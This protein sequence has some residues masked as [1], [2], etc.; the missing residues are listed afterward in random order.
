M[1]EGITGESPAAT[2]LDD[3]FQ[4]NAA[5]LLKDVVFDHHYRLLPFERFVERLRSERAR[6]DGGYFVRPPTGPFATLI[7]LADNTDYDAIARTIGIWRLQSCP[8]VDCAVVAA[9]PDFSSGALVA[10]L[11]KW[12]AEPPAAILSTDRTSWGA[13]ANSAY[14]IFARPG[15]AINPSLCVTME[16][17]ALGGPFDLFYWNELQRSS[18]RSTQ[19]LFKA[20]VDVWRRPRFERY[21]LQHVAYIGCGFA[22]RTPLVLDFDGDIVRDLIENEGHLFHLWLLGRSVRTRSSAEYLGTRAYR[23]RPPS[24]RRRVMARFDEYRHRLAELAPSFDVVAIDNEQQPYV[25]SPQRRAETISVVIPFRDKADL[26]VRCLASLAAQVTAAEIDVVLV[27]NQ[28]VAASVRAVEAAA[29]ERFRNGIRWSL[30]NYDAVFNHSAQCNLGI[31][32]SKGEVV[33]LMNNDA[34]FV[35]PNALDELAAWSLVDDVG[36]AGPRI[37]S[38]SD[39]IVWTGMRHRHRSYGYGDFP[40]HESRDRRF[41]HN[42]RETF[43]NTFA[44]VAIARRRFATVGPLDAARYPAGY[45]DVDFALRARRAGFTHVYLGHV[46][47][48][49]EKGA[50]RLQADEHREQISLRIEY[51]ELMDQLLFQL[52]SDTAL[53]QRVSLKSATA[54]GRDWRAYLTPEHLLRFRLVSA[55]M[56]ISP[57]RRLAR[58]IYHRIQGP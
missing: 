33:F 56:R 30:S 23:N 50:S 31:E 55:A 21:T 45:N 26:T 7:V 46:S 29:E 57:L 16:A 32:R 11:G 28:S 25:L 8:W 13:V 15:D 42:I 51:G 27:N 3:Q 14:L 36:S 22:V 39:A 1:H 19:P 12:G 10:A 41:E 52:E 47:V 38:P 58:S 35:S 4:K 24:P 40:I 44:A 18:L 2:W 6:H 34:Y 20:V 5:A 48:A 53:R 9:S 37:Q 54:D 43:G 49:H 17:D